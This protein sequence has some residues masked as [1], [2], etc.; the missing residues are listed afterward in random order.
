[1]LNITGE[2]VDCVSTCR[3]ALRAN[4]LLYEK[5]NRFTVLVPD[6]CDVLGLHFTTVLLLPWSDAEKLIKRFLNLVKH[7][8]K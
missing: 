7:V 5:A 3:V 8:F 4:L 2:N 1:M 6:I